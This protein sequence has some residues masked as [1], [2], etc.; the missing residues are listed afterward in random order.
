MPCGKPNEAGA[1]VGLRS[2][3]R[4]LRIN[5]DA[6]E[7][8]VPDARQDGAPERCRECRKKVPSAGHAVDSRDG[9]CTGRTRPPCRLVAASIHG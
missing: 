3:D 6:T 4:R 8:H 9:T 2:E 1:A 5:R 7:L